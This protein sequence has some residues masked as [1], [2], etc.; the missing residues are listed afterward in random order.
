V[1]TG[2]GGGYFCPTAAVMR[3]QMAVFIAGTFG[4]RLYG[5]RPP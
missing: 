1:V 5:P 2:C 3:E 4:L